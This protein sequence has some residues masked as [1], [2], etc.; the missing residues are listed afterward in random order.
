[1]KKQI[2]ELKRVFAQTGKLFIPSP[3]A[4]LDDEFQTASF[5][6]L[7]KFEG[8]EMLF[9]A[10]MMTL[11]QD[12]RMNITEQTEERMLNLYPELEE[13]SYDDFTELQ[14]DEYD[15]IFESIYRSDLIKVQ[16]NI[17]VHPSNS[18]ECMELDITLDVRKIDDKVIQD[19]IRNFNAKSLELNE[20]LRSF[21]I[22]DEL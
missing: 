8:K 7:G 12:Y 10:F 4:E 14:K 11:I 17:T 13:E 15:N 5:M 21:D 16:E 19:F 6:F 22:D 1:M 18:G 3:E 9:D 20:N 2:E